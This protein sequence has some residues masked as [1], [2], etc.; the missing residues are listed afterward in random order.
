MSIIIKIKTNKE[1]RSS[2][3]GSCSASGQCAN[4][5]NMVCLLSTCTCSNPNLVY[6]NGTYCGRKLLFSKTV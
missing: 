1:K 6:W 2:Y 4:G 3:G 5:T